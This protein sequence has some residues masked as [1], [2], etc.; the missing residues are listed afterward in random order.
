MSIH[1][2]VFGYTLGDVMS[3]KMERASRGWYLRY[4]IHGNNEHD[5]ILL[6]ASLYLKKKNIVDNKRSTL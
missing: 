6:K 3:K 1:V 4:I 5:M 2:I